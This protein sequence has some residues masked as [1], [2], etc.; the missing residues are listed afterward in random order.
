M[1]RIMLFLQFVCILLAMMVVVASPSDSSLVGGSSATDPL[2]LSNE[3][4]EKDPS[5]TAL[6]PSAHVATQTQS[7]A[8]PLPIRPT[9]PSFGLLDHVPT[10]VAGRLNM[11]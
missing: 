8:F 6:I 3:L 7:T 2:G 11:V 4:A 10:L 5:L 1:F 9:P